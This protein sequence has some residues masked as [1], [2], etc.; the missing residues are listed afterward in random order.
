MIVSIDPRVGS[1]DLVGPLKQLGIPAEHKQLP[2]GDAQVVGRGPGDRPVLIGVEI[3]AIGDLL[4]CIVD[5]RFVGG[6]LGGLLQSYE[7]VFL[8]IEGVITASPTRELLVLRHERGPHGDALRWR[9][10]MFGTRPWTYESVMSWVHSVRRAGVHDV[11]TADR[12]GTA[13]WIAS[14]A[15]NW[16]KPWDEHKTLVGRM[17]KPMESDGEENALAEFD[18]TPPMRIAGSLAR[19]IGWKKAAAAAKHFKS[20]KKI[21]NAT[22][23]AWLAVP[24]IGKKLA[25]EAVATANR[26][27]W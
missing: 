20:P 9:K 5:K 21:V 15:T 25:A 23:E 16:W 22:E 10:A 26:E 14:L 4:S 1:G 8:L 7:I 27:E 11:Y 17:Q 2:Y 24:G 3:K 6:Q 19:G 18:A 12:R 13:A